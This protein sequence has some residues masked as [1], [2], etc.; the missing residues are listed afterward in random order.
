ML[1]QRINEK[2][3]R[4]A[5]EYY[6]KQRATSSSEGQAEIK[7]EDAKSFLNN[8]GYGEP[9]IPMIQQWNNKGMPQTS[10]FNS[11]I[12]KLVSNQGR[13]N[14]SISNKLIAYHTLQQ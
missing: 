9:P 3:D 11:P 14:D 4:A 13:I 2:R 6:A 5:K 7:K 12:G 1:E 10:V 8:G